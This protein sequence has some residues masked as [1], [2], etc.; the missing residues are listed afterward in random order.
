MS[1]Q[2]PPRPGRLGTAVVKL[3][4]RAWRDRYADE[5]LDLLAHRPPGP[6]AAADLLL[7]ALDAHLNITELLRGAATMLAQ[8]RRAALTTLGAW[9]ALCL[10][11]AGLIKVNEDLAYRQAEIAHPLLGGADA[12]AQWACV[13]AGALVLVGGLPLA[14]T[15]LR[16]AW[17]HDRAALPLF[18]VPPAAG[19]VWLGTGLLLGLLGRDAALPQWLGR[20]AFCGWIALAWVAAAVSVAA[21]G[22]LLRRLELAARL[23]RLAT[24]AGGLVAAAVTVAALSLITYAVELHTAEPA[25]FSG[26]DGI[27]ATPLPFTLIPLTVIGTA[28]AVLADR[29]AWR[30]IRALP[31]A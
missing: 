23:L 31:G 9:V 20:A 28:A 13:V 18:A 8:L 30:G 14:V 15:G 12:T 25:L 19:A 2:A 21:V 6:R 17:R 27:I 10:T 5:V 11:V 16:E 29:A 4:P 24:V 22:R 3:Y 7:G 26:G 1:G